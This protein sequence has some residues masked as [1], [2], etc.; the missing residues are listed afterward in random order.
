MRR[1]LGFRADCLIIIKCNAWDSESSVLSHDL[2]FPACA[3]VC[4]PLR[5]FKGNISAACAMVQKSLCFMGLLGYAVFP[6]SYT[7]LMKLSS[8]DLINPC[9]IEWNLVSCVEYLK[10]LHSICLT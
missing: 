3:G 7:K 4:D 1:R 8:L 9:E 2:S 10:M 5:T 6:A